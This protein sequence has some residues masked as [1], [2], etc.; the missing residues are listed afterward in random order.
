MGTYSPLT[1]R[2]VRFWIVSPMKSGDK[3]KFL[4][5]APMEVIFSQTEK[6]LSSYEAYLR[7]N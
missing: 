1:S 3:F 5:L 7:K 2:S 4:I 6:I